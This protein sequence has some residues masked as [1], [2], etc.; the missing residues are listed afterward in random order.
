MARGILGI[1]HATIHCKNQLTIL[2]LSRKN[3]NRHQNIVFQAYHNVMLRIVGNIL[4]HHIYQVIYVA[5]YKND[6]ML[7]LVTLPKIKK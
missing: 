1:K 2:R 4:F 5:V 6:G 7:F 3:S